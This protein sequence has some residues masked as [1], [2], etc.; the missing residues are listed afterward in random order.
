MAEK[1]SPEEKQE[2]LERVEQKAASYMYE[3][4]GCG[5]AVLLALQQ[6]FDLPGG[7]AVIKSA[8]YLGRGIARSGDACAALL[9]AIMALG[10][11]SGRE[12]MEDP[13]YPEPK[14]I[15][16]AS[17]LP[18]SLVQVRGFYQRCAELIGGTTCRDC[19]LKMFGKTFDLGKPKEND[20]FSKLSD[21]KCSEVVGKIARLAAETILEMPRR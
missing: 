14:V 13:T 20:E 10:L 17:K 7:S 5:Q 15:D 19:Q 16:E 11:A 3:Y 18:K 2:I 4:K 9:G 6:E 12:N 1:V 21:T 8:S